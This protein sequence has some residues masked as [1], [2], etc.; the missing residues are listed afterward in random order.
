MEAHG[1]SA[2]G[3]HT[4]TGYPP[5]PVVPSYRSAG[6]YIPGATRSIIENYKSKGL[7]RPTA[8]LSAVD[9]IVIQA[10]L[11]SRGAA[12]G[13][14]Q[15]IAD[16]IY[17]AFADYE[18]SHSTV[19]GF[20]PSHPKMPVVLALSNTD[21]DERLPAHV[22]VTRIPI[23]R[24]FFALQETPLD[25]SLFPAPPRQWTSEV[26]ESGSSEH[27]DADSQL[28]RHIDADQRLADSPENVGHSGQ[29]PPAPA[30][31]GRVVMGPP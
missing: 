6:R 4:P 8:Q 21:L 22:A 1:T 7:L 17:R 28:S 25:R 19:L 29:Y 9:L 12:P 11:A 3:V 13:A 20:S 15:V 18:V 31:E 24:W 30:V 16:R 2:N 26:R 10:L 27:L 14:E 23:G 5:L